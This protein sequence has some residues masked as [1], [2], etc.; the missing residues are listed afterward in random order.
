MS[1]IEEALRQ[2]GIGLDSL[3]ILLGAGIFFFV[4]VKLAEFW[5]SSRKAQHQLA[6]VPVPP[7]SIPIP[8]LGHVI[9][10]IKDAPWEVMERWCRNYGPIVRF[11]FFN[12]NYLVIADVEVIKHVLATNLKNYKKDRASYSPFLPLLGTGLVTSE[13]HLWRRQRTLISGAFRVEILGEAAIIACQAAFRLIDKINRLIQ[14]QTDDIQSVTIEMGEE[15]RLL[16]LQVIGQA[17]L[18]LSPDESDKVFPSLYLPIV[19]EANKRTWYPFR[20]FLPTPSNIAYQRSIK[21]LNDYVTSTIRARIHAHHEATAK[22]NNENQQRFGQDKGDILDRIIEGAKDQKLDDEAVLQLRDE[23]KT[24]LF[25]GHETT[26]MMLTWTLFE[27]VSNPGCMAKVLEEANSV[28]KPELGGSIPEYET[29]RGLSYTQNALKEALRKYAIV[30]VV[31]REAIED[32]I[33]GDFSIPKNTKVVLPIIAIH[34]NPELWPDPYAFKPERFDEP[35][36]HPYAW[37]GF[38]NGPRNC[39]GQ[40]FA[41]LEAKIVLALLLQHFH[42]GLSS[43][44]NGKKHPSKI[45]VCLLDGLHVTFKPREATN[46]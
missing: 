15:F 21:K 36:V 14:K 1:F 2:S 16:T 20:A 23:I 11:N 42:I 13:G 34:H 24:F 44:T 18:S 32:D 26:S 37:L 4:L 28:F 5:F 6:A 35:P 17:V 19:E 40:H 12:L 10:L 30:P 9:D 7:T 29:L 31:T 45:P 39:V 25:A 27:L 3:L 8:S 41:L 46:A 43:K 38:I 22:G 33:L